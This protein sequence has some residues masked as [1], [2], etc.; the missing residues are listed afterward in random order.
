M[1]GQVISLGFAKTFLH[2]SGPT[3][4]AVSRFNK[5][6]PRISLLCSHAAV[7]LGQSLFPL[8]ALALNLSEN[9]FDDK[10]SCTYRVKSISIA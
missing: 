10:V 4:V 9:F 1:F 5:A 7:R 2:T 6:H 8:F 3:H